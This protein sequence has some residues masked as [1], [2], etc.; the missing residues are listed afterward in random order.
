M[1]TAAMLPNGAGHRLKQDNTEVTDQG[2]HINQARGSSSLSLEAVL[3]ALARQHRVLGRRAPG[4]F[5][6]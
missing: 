6:D 3:T 1:L 5:S 4:G 2:D